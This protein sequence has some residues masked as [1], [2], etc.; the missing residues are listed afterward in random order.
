MVRRVSTAAGA[1]PPWASGTWRPRTPISASWDQ[2]SRLQP[3]G[4]LRILARASKA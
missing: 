2:I 3:S 1:I 4:D